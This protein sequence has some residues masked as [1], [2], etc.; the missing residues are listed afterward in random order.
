MGDW[1]DDYAE[2]NLRIA[3]KMLQQQ[4]ELNRLTAD[5]AAANAALTSVGDL[6]DEARVQRDAALEDAK[7]AW[8]YLARS[9]AEIAEEIAVAIEAEAGDL[10]QYSRRDE[11]SFT[12]GRWLQS[13]AAVAREH[14]TAPT[15]ANSNG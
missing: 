5:L 1:R 7:Q 12:V 8:F 2:Q 13:M 4:G 15:E 11:T 14:A 3:Q 10:G 9:R 6:L